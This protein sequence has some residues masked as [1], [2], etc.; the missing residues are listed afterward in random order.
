MPDT[1]LP[2]WADPKLTPTQRFT[3]MVDDMNA[4]MAAARPRGWDDLPDTTLRCG[5]PRKRQPWLGA[6]KRAETVRPVRNAKRRKN[7]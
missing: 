5:P 2:A 1:K 6:P 3:A 7:K 4:T